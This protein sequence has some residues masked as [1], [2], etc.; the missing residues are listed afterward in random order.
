MIVL[1]QVLQ[2]ETLMYRLVGTLAL[3]AVL[4]HTTF[5]CCLHHAHA[6]AVTGDGECAS[7]AGGCGDEHSGHTDCACPHGREPSHG[8]CDRGQCSFVQ[9]EVTGGPRVSSE[10]QPLAPATSF[11]ETTGTASRNTIDT[12]D[13]RRVG[14]CEPV[15]LHL[16]NQVLLI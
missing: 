8:P 13:R 9:P 12:I 3:A 14:C 5:G 16:L 6:E 2:P 11:P 1:V 15:R 7:G 4:A 10:R